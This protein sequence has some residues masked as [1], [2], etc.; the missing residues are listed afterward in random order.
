MN[1]RLAVNGDLPFWAVVLSL[2]LV[3]ISLGVLVVHELR[4]RDRGGAAIVGTGVLAI[5]ALLAAVIRPVRIAARES[6]IGAKVV[7]LADA[8]RSM[9]LPQDGKSRRAIE[10]GALEALAKKS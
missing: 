2:C 8:S 4:K 1:T 7:V 3:E 10:A 5:L 9:A 6:V